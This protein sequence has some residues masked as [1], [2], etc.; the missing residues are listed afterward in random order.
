MRVEAAYTRGNY[1]Q[2]EGADEREL[3]EDMDLNRAFLGVRYRF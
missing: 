1:E 3:R 2:A